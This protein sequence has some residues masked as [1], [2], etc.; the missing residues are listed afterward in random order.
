MLRAKTVITYSPSRN[1]NTESLIYN[2]PYERAQAGKGA[3][4]GP[5]GRIPEMQAL[6]CDIISREARGAGLGCGQD[7]AEPTRSK[8]HLPCS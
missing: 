1:S 3:R 7:S 8:E 6:R 4:Q 5:I 2:N